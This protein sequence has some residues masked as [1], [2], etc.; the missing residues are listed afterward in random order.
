MKNALLTPPP[1][2]SLLRDQL[3]SIRRVYLRGNRIVRRDDFTRFDETVL[4]LHGFFQTRNVWE[5]ME[6]RLRD[7]GYGVFSFDLGGLL[8][9]F[10]TRS[11]PELSA[12]IADKI[13]GI[14]ARTGL[15][16]F[17]IVGHS[18]GGIVARHYV[19]HHGGDKRVKSVVT[20][21]S[22]HH[23]TP[24]AAIGVGLMA[25]GLISKS[26][27]QMLP[28]SSLMRMLRKDSFP[29]GVPLSSIYSR[30]DVVCPWWCSVLRP[31][32]GETSMTNHEVRGVGHTALTSDQV[33]YKIIR[34]R[35]DE[36]SELWVE[37]QR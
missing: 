18:K 12:T 33:V 4:L 21:G 25:G 9:R 32:P 27:I 7:H 13:E 16:R 5:V 31:R 30:H 3:G 14:C 17:H 2:M 15:E 19:Q 26:P 34:D 28:G 10:N 24:T 29:P 20:L 6:D 8:W 37:R 36:A 1:L 22:P 23:G 11:I 35:L